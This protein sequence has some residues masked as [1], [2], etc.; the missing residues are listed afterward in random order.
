MVFEKKF[1]FS[2]IVDNRWQM[3]RPGR[4]YIMKYR[5]MGMR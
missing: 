4:F 5:C 1:I 2:I 3:I